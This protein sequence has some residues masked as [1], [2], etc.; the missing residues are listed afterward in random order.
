MIAAFVASI[1]LAAAAPEPQEA[2]DL[3]TLT[4]TTLEQCVASPDAVGG[5]GM[6]DVSDAGWA[7]P[8]SDG[9][10]CGLRA[11]DWRGDDGALTAAARRAVGADGPGWTGPVRDSRPNERGPALWTRL[12]RA[13]GGRQTSLMVIEPPAGQRGSV[14]IYYSQGWP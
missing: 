14:E 8:F 1:Q 13:E 11:D 4:R 12:E 7:W 5:A 6:L 3:T 2:P 9:F 10:E